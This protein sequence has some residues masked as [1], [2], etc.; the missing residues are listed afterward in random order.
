VLPAGSHPPC[1][2]PAPPGD[3]RED[4]RRKYCCTA[5][6]PAIALAM[7]AL[8]F[9]NL[10]ISGLRRRWPTAPSDQLSATRMIAGPPRI[11][12]GGSR[13][14]CATLCGAAT[15]P[16]V[17]APR[18]CRATLP[19]KNVLEGARSRGIAARTSQR[20]T[21]LEKDEDCGLGSPG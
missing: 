11:R 14:L 2:K 18:F 20:L 17:R 15:G 10:A 3:D 13:Q 1:V 6:G 8:F 7:L 4:I 16:G 9:A 5:M 12:R 19:L 21:R